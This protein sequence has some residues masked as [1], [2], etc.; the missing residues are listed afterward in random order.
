M[1]TEHQ[2]ELNRIRT[3]RFREKHPEKD[4]E[5]RKRWVAKDPEHVKALK[6]AKYHRNKAKQLD[7]AKEQ[8]HLNLEVS[9]KKGRDR[10]NR[11]KRRARRKNAAGISTV[12]SRLARVEYHGWKCRYCGCELVPETLTIDHMIPLIRGGTDW[13]ANLVPA[14]KPCNSRKQTKTFKEY[15][16]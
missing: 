11:K 7:R 10:L 5:Y 15:V 9:R 14:C 1:L 12:E 3:Q 6:R 2:R 8:Y 4:A 16:A 13:P